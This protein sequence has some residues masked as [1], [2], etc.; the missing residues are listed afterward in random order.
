MSPSDQDDYTTFQQDQNL[1]DFRRTGIVNPGSIA[2][3]DD[4]SEGHVEAAR[5]RAAYYAL[6]V[7][8]SMAGCLIR[9]G[10]DA[11]GACELIC[12][13]IGDI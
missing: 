1:G 10:L 11:L 12:P 13:C 9:L 4:K 2:R 5:K 6:L 3:I 7:F 8:F